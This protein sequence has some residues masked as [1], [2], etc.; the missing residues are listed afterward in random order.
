MK[1]MILELLTFY[2][3]VKVYY[4]IVSL[5]SKGNHVFGIVLI[6]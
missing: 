1:T 6:R 4:G 3:G 2:F 5:I